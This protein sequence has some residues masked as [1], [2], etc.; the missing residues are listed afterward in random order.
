MT[1]CRIPVAAIPRVGCPRRA[2]GRTLLA[3]LGHLFGQLAAALA[4]YG[5][6]LGLVFSGREWIAFCS[7]I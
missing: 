2:Q 7:K 4:R 3:L 5:D 6:V 1:V